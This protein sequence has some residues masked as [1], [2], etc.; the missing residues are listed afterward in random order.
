MY[1]KKKINTHYTLAKEQ[2]AED[3]SV[4]GFHKRNKHTGSYD[5]EKLMELVPELVPLVFKNKF[6]HNT[7][8]FSDSKSVML[9]NKALLNDFYGLDKWEIPKGYLCPPVPGRSDYIHHIADLLQ[10]NNFGTIPLDEKVNV[11]DVGV[12]ANAIYA[13]ISALE[14]GWS[15]VGVDIDEKA[16]RSAK[17]II[18]SHSKLSELVSVRRQENP[19]NVFNG[20][21]E[22]SDRFDVTVCNPP[23]H[24]S[25]EEANKGT[26]RK[27]RGLQSG[28]GQKLQRNFE[29]TG[30]ELWYEGGESQFIQNMIIQ[31]KNYSEQCF[32]FTTLV[33]KK[34]NLRAIHKLLRQY[35][36]AKVETIELGH[37]NKS[38]RV[39]AWTFL[40]KEAQQNW[41]AKRWRK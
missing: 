23:F 36:A 12:G 17:N 2:Q 26:F 35:K 16:I 37:G 28:K 7:I 11:L 6:N 34:S 39:V 10:K 29:G 33:S 32:W 3:K 20:V 25:L 18:A 30:N 22:L 27:L 13:I 4:I 15:V 8:D 1:K 31:S 9:L 24:S 14:Y 40:N 21:I 38:S 5:F 19:K 41:K